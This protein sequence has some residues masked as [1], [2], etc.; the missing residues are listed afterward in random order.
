[1]ISSIYLISFFAIILGLI[2]WARFESGKADRLFRIMTIGALLTYFGSWVAQIAPVDYKVEVIVRDLMVIAASGAVFTW[3]ARKRKLFI[4]LLAVVVAA[5]YW[6][7]KNVLEPSSFPYVMEQSEIEL[8]S[9]GELLVELVPD[10]T[11]TQISALEDFLMDH[12]ANYEIAFPDIQRADWTDLDDYIL[13]NSIND[14]GIDAL[15]SKLAAFP[16]VENV[17]YN[18]MIQLSPIESV[19]Q[20]RDQKRRVDPQFGIDDPGVEQLWSFR[21]MKMD[22]LYNVLEK[23]NIQPQKKALI[24][25]LDTGVDSKH[26]DI[27]DNYTS[28]VKSSDD[29]PKGHGTHC[30]GIAAAV[31]NNGVGV[32][33][34]SRNNAYTRVTSIKVLSKM[35]F[36]SQKMIINGILKAADKGADVISMSLG[37]PSNDLKQKAYSDA[38][39][40]AN[41]KGAIVVAAAGNSNAN[42]KNYG[43]VNAKGIIGV[44]AVDSELKKA[45]FSNTVQDLKMGIAA[46]GVGIYSTIPGSQYATYNGTSMATPY[47]AGLI[48]LMKSINPDIKTDEV[49]KILK[50]TGVKTGSTR[51]TGKFIQ[52]AAAVKALTSK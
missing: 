38:V 5:G 13:V 11:P 34:Y 7:Y 30:A 18:E 14:Q 44:S 37:G 50:E 32:A 35:G 29:D 2:F 39:A 4:L 8:D 16:F 6:Y 25:I 20:E 19:P 12:N 10:F 28:I 47:V 15:K 21:Q 23:E 26:E 46:P 17:E 48:G 41:K 24:A 40:Y 27:K 51:E 42:S 45:S 49:Y 9:S 36:G 1:M 33:S 22:Q 3:V 31:T 43:P 52:P